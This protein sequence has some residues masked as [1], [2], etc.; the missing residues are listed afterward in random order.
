MLV[1]IVEESVDKRTKGLS[2]DKPD[3]FNSCFLIYVDQSSE[4]EEILGDADDTVILNVSVTHCVSHCDINRWIQLFQL[5][6][7][8]FCPGLGAYVTLLEEEVG[9]EIVNGHGCGV[10]DRD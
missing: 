8:S 9:R 2:K 7:G 1:P 3:V 5:A 6:D 4:I 10:V